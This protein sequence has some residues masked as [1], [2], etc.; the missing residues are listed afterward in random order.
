[1]SFPA[2]LALKREA[3]EGNPAGE[4]YDRQRRGREI[5]RVHQED[6]CQALGVLPHRKYQNEGGPGVGDLVSLLRTHSS[7]RAEDVDT[8]V[9]AVGFNWL[10]AGTD[11]HA[12]NYSILLA[13]GPRV[14]LAPLYDVAGILPYGAFDMRKVK[15]AMKI[16]GTYELSMIGPRQWRKLAREIRIDEGGMIDALRGMAN[17]LPDRMEETRRA[18]KKEGL[19][20]AV[21]DRLASRIL[22]RLKACDLK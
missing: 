16:G 18:A 3:R 8:F 7:E 2:S 12:K 21:I 5:I 1:M 20:H 17:E 22:A 10:V 9:R 6:A 4:R 11:A 19:D 14:R 15:F 13:S